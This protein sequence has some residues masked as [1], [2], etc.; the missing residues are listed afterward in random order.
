MPSATSGRA[1]VLGALLIVGLALAPASVLAQTPSDHPLFLALP[2]RFPELDARVVLIREPSRDVVVLNPA[3]A[4]PEALF[5]GLRLLR[6]FRD[7]PRPPG[8][9]QMIPIT[10]FVVP[11][12][13]YEADRARLE[14]YL[15]E[16]RGR[17]VT[18]LGTLGAGRWLALDAR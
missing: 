16:L 2:E 3:D 7:R 1:A 11:P 8:E 10:G 17:P 5:T 12:A 15:A 18:G 14:R 9:G 6:R 13:L 4:T